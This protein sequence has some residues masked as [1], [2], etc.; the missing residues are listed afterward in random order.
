[1]KVKSNKNSKSKKK[2]NS[3]QRLA[4]GK[5]AKYSH[6]RSPNAHYEFLSKHGSAKNVNSLSNMKL[7]NPQNYGSQKQRKPSQGNKSIEPTPEQISKQKSCSRERAHLSQE[8][9]KKRENGKK[10]IVDFI[11]KYIKKNNEVEINEAY[12]D[13]LNNLRDFLEYL[14][15][16][17][18]INGQQLEDKGEINHLIKDLM[19]L[20]LAKFHGL[21]KN[22]DKK[23]KTG[24]RN[25]N[26]SVNRA[27]S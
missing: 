6:Q 22:I 18:I 16:K 13:T 7:Y 11:G 5:R 2:M 10:Q 3:S 15:D 27:N 17:N 4:D 24:S 12:D 21:R 1:M 23:R 19:K 9:I 20:D 26:V 25:V 8:R 14:E